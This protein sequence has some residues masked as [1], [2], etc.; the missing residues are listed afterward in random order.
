MRRGIIAAVGCLLL[1]SQ[2]AFAGW[3]QVENYEGSIG[4][5]PIHLS[6]QRY[7]G[8]GSGITVN[9][10][11]FY[12]ARQIPIAIYGKADGTKLTLARLRTTR[13]SGG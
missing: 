1:L 3:Y 6:L 8:F 4:P 9:G 12:D 2:K 13:N 7:D 11:Y 5:N 10:S